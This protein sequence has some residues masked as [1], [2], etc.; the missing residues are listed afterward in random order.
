SKPAFLKAF[1]TDLQLREYADEKGILLVSPTNLYAILKIVGDFWKVAQQY[2]NALDI[3]EKA[4]ALYDK[5]TGFIDNMESVG[6]KLEDA[7]NF[8]TEA[9]KHLS[10]G[11]GNLRGR[12]EDLKNGE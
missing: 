8:Y 3:A 6:K 2:W 5:F 11:R 10:S 7:T 9:F 12:I 4:N 1:K